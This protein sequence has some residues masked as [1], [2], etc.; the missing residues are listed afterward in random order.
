V[1]I[2]GHLEV[3]DFARVA[4]KSG[5]SNDL[6]GAKTYGSA[7]PVVEIERYRRIVAVWRSLPELLRRVRQ[8]EKRL[9]GSP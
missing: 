9:G 2:A 6:P 4:A 8:L 7:I 1:G 3:G 5:V